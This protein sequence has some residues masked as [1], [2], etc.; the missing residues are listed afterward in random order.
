MRIFTSTSSRICTKPVSKDEVPLLQYG[1]IV[2]IVWRPIEVFLVVHDC[3]GFTGATVAVL[4]FPGGQEIGF[5]EFTCEMEYIQS[6]IIAYYI[7]IL[8]RQST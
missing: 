4:Y 6:S 2:A 3:L 5:D 1:L 7:A 8:Q